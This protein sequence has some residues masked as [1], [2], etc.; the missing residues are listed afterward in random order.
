[1]K[2]N[3]HVIV[4]LRAFNERWLI[5]EALPE[6]PRLILHQP[7]KVL[8]HIKIN[9]ILPLLLADLHPLLAGKALIERALHLLFHIPVLYDLHFIDLRLIQHG[10]ALHR[11]RVRPLLS[12]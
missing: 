1:M 12:L 2:S 5:R 9:Q 3:G 11:C 10:L 7:L 4:L 8:E 6:S